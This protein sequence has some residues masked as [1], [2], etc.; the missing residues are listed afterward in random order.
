MPMQVW[1]LGRHFL[2]AS[3]DHLGKGPDAKSW[4][5]PQDLSVDGHVTVA[6]EG[7]GYLGSAGIGK[8]LH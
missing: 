5:K 1:T 3:Q 7:A 8:N 2:E 6:T 4:L